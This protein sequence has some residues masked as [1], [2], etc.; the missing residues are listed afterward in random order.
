LLLIERIVAEHAA[1]AAGA[2]VIFD[3]RM[4]RRHRS[5][6]ALGLL[7]VACGGGAPP[8]SKTPPVA[9]VT[10]SAS[11][12]PT[13]APSA[14]VKL[15]DATPLAT[16][17][18]ATFTGPAGWTSEASST[19]IVLTGPEADLRVA[20]VDAKSANVDD[21][22]VA[23]WAA[24]APDF[25]R[26]PKLVQNRPG[27]RGWDE[28][29][30]Y[31][32]E[33]SPNERLEAFA[34]ALRHG[35]TWTIVLVKS[36]EAS[37]EKRG[38]DVQLV[39]QSLRPKGYTKESFAGKQAHDLDA[40]RIKQ[41]TDMIEKTQAEAA[42]PGVAISLV[43]A[44]KV[45]FQ[46][47]FGVREKGKPAKVDE[48]TQFL[49]ASN[50]K[51]M[52]TLL[53]AK[54]VDEGKLR[55]D[56]PAK[57]AYPDF[58]LG[59]ADTTNKVQIKHLICA[60]TGMP[61]QD[62]EM[63]F[64]GAKT[65]P[66]ARMKIL[67]TFQP[68]TKFGETFQYSNIMASAAGYVGGSIAFPKKELGAA[69]DEAMQS[70]VFGPLGMKDTTFD[71]GKALRGNH[72]SSHGF[73]VKGNTGVS[74]TEFNRLILP[75]RPA[76]GA[77]SSVKDVTKYVMMELANGKLP[78]GAAYVSEQSLLAR[79]APQVRISETATYGMGL[80]VD[81]DYGITI[82]HHGGDLLGMHSDMFWL[83]EQGVGGVI[84]TNADAG[85]LLRKPFLRKVLEVLFD[86]QA[87]A[88]E[89]AL[90][91][92]KRNVEEH[93]KEF[94]RLVVPP[95]P[96]ATAKLATKYVSD[97]LG[98]LTVKS[99]GAKR[100]FDFGGWAS[101]MGSKK[102]D[103][104]TMSLMTAKPGLVGFTFVAGDRDGKRA[105]VTHDAQHEYV[106]LETK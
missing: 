58:K 14:P 84:L 46:G 72:A 37:L 47:G 93:I 73:D 27:R 3:A 102:N 82:V 26:P 34:Q 31:T 90:S 53:L 69:Y 94:E 56:E 54:L 86:G 95:D 77:W 39:G 44:G 65:T 41:I 83:P 70:R 68:T 98:D 25:K 36:S 17:G 35:D 62:F 50:T 103:D 29:R 92:I 33:I 74:A 18:G 61:R 66:L 59:D 85:V 24:F 5:S 60:C 40:A 38:A 21:E 79:R 78:S 80:M 91:A 12:T 48:S 57:E 1:L 45:V 43:Q 105:L 96:E 13:D 2:R 11:A 104:G 4:T 101:E 8:S 106:F 7:L 42:V 97:G 23:A 99:D 67:G 22:V 19:R 51:A 6:L 49:I 30:V 89:D 55:W 71:F 52:T 87:E 20:I 81:T 63:I 28:G 16:P 64:Q 10:P 75:D 76:G 9:S 32:Y 15:A 88:E 100:I